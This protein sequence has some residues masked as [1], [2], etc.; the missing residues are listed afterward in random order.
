M[1]LKQH[2]VT[3][4]RGAQVYYSPE[5]ASE[6]LR[7][8][9]NLQDNVLTADQLRAIAREAGVSDEN[10]ERAMEQFE[11]RRTSATQQPQQRTKRRGWLKALLGLGVTG[12]MMFSACLAFPLLLRLAYPPNFPAH[13][14]SEWGEGALLASSPSLGIY[15]VEVTE[16]ERPREVII[17]RHRTGYDFVVGRSFRNIVLASIAPSERY[18]ALYDADTGEI[19]VV[20]RTGEGLQLVGRSGGKIELH[21]RMGFLALEDPLVGWAPSVYSDVLQVRSRDGRTAGITIH[22][23]L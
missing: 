12:I 19:Y 15:K 23:E 7:L 14:T 2:Q 1:A 5:E 4:N 9:A 16:K 3:D 13:I 8:A 11:R 21:G 18:V 6:I 17:I 10:L 22:T 20:S